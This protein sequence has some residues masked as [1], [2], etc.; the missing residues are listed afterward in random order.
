MA[1]WPGAINRL[2]HV[3]ISGDAT[4]SE[5]HIYGCKFTT[6]NPPVLTDISGGIASVARDAEGIYT[7]TFDTAFFTGAAISATLYQA[8][9]DNVAYSVKLTDAAADSI[10]VEVRISATN[11]L[12]DAAGTSVHLI[13]FGV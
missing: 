8:A 11:A 9:T 1:Y 12:E 4:V 3:A 6:A 13:A 10:K 5:M 7:V 2:D